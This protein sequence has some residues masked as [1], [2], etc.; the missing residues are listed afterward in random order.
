ME[1][2]EMSLF[3]DNSAELVFDHEQFEDDTVEETEDSQEENINQDPTEQEDAENVGDDVEDDEESEESESKDKSSPNLYSSIVEVLKDQGIIPSL[4]SSKEIKTSEDLISVLKQEIEIQSQKRLE[5]Y[6]ENL[7]TSKII[8][9]K[10]QLTSLAEIDEDVLKADTKLAKELIYQDY[11]NQGLSEDRAKKLLKKTIDLGEDLVIEDALES[12][13]S[14]KQFEQNRIKL[15]QENYKK[16]IKAQED[17][18]RQLDE[19]LKTKIFSTDEFVTGVKASK[20]LQEKVYKS[21]T[22]IVGK[23]PQGILE[24][25]L[26]KDRSENPIDFDIRMYAL[27][28]LTNGFKDVSKVIKDTKSKAVKDLETVIRKT[29]IEDNGTPSWM[30]DSGSYSSPYDNQE[31]VL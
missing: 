6:V 22:E 27:Y 15:E 19:Q 18:Q 3:S 5:D 13:E 26:M 20:A 4:E 14:L 16:Q 25:K 9:S 28:E 12:L 1:E 10:Q 30:Q 8:E 11:L 17:E 23:N 7:D 29:R 31:L 21:M 2:N 24:N